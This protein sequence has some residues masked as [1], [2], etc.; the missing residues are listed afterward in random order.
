MKHSNGVIAAKSLLLVFSL[1]AVLGAA[2]FA[3]PTA[4]KEQGSGVITKAV[5]IVS[6]PNAASVSI[7]GE[8]VGKTP[9]VVDVAVNS[10]GQC[11]RPLVIRAQ[12]LPA[13]AYESE[14]FFPGKEKDGNSNF[15]PA[16][17]LFDLNVQRV[18]T[19]R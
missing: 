13:F 7:N 10:E 19:L 17:L 4:L 3:G 2:C 15:V 5:T 8:Y 12:K 16:V 11:V 9:C 1:Q 6:A 18:V 14:R